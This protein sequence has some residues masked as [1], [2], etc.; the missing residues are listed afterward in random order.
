MDA[1]RCGEHWPC[2]LEA[3]YNGLGMTARA[4]RLT[5]L[6]SA[7]CLAFQSSLMHCFEQRLPSHVR[8]G[9]QVGCS[10]GGFARSDLKHLFPLLVRCILPFFKME[11]VWILRWLRKGFIVLSPF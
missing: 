3:Q 2:C 8:L 5:A 4:Q 11:F 1:E 6:P 7:E 9:G 10:S